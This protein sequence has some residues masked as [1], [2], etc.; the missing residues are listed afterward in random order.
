VT[1]AVYGA[2]QAGSAVAAIL[3]ARGVS[4][5]GPFGR[6]E[7]DAALRS[8]AA[9]VLIA[10]TSFLADIADDVRTAI[11]AGSNVLTTAEEAAFPWTIDAALADE[12]D[13]RAV[14]RGVTVLGAGLNPGFAFDALVLTALGATADPRA[15]R[16]ERVVDLSGFGPTVLRRIGVGHALDAFAAGVAS[17]TITGH[18]GFPQSMRIVAER[19]GRTIARIDRDIVPIVAQHEH[20]AAHLTVA[21]GET[22]G[23]EQRYTAIVDDAPWFHARFVGHVDPAAAG[24]ATHDE[25]HVED[26]PPI[27]L[28]I[29]PGLSSQ[30]ASAAVLANSVD[31]LVAARPGWLTVADL[32][33]AVPGW[34]SLGI[35]TRTEPRSAR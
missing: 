23:F 10:T 3:R 26:D 2:G 12:L 27:H 18:I 5:R 20:A 35:V 17:G 28:T 25:I 32:P 14:A 9:V 24:L 19:L 16:V 34:Y 22:A 1:V 31:R 15:L 6:A 4:V 7:R 11:D 33:P 8:G 13:A 30:S 21:A 29:A